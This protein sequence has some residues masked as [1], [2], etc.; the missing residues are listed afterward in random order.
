M[1]LPTIL[2]PL[3]A[4][5]PTALLFLAACGG[6]PAPDPETSATSGA[7]TASA[8]SGAAPSGQASAPAAGE[9]PQ[10]SAPGAATPQSANTKVPAEIRAAVD[11]ADRSE[12]DK[13]L[14]PGRHPAELLAF[15]GVAPGMKVAEL[16]AGG[17]YTAEL[18]ARVV[19]PSGT[20][21]GQ[22]S[23]FILEKFAAKPWS[24]RLA[25]PLM[26]NAVRVDR[27][28][29]E[30]LPPEAKNLDVVFLIMFYHDTVWMKTDRAKMNKNI[31][32][33]LKPGGVYAI[34]DHSSRAGAG[35]TEVQT[36]HRIEEKILR[37]EVERAG[38]KLAAEGSF[39]RSASDKRDWSTSP[40][41][42]GEQRGTSDRFVL[43]FVKPGG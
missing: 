41:T 18:L 21:Y 14:D 43:K 24:E 2:R 4:S 39:L 7:G 35:L 1:R 40:S 31:F 23:K 20:V 10:E 17:G 22:N 38:F 12:A 13:K 6:T 33:A 34:V 37:E 36:L 26:K 16:G 32:D 11:A 5:L 25:K 30:P 19:G 15:F 27:E 29:D 9:K 28:F 8:T 3:F 42:A